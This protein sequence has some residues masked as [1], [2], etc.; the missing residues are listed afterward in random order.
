MNGA[1]MTSR[2]R[3]TMILLVALIANPLS[4]CDRSAASTV[5]LEVSIAETTL[6]GAATTGELI[7]TNTSGQRLTVDSFDTS[8]GCTTLETEQLTL[9]PGGSVRVPLEIYPTKQIGTMSVNV[10]ARSAGNTLGESS[11]SLRVVPAAPSEIEWASEIVIPL[12]AEYINGLSDA[13]CYASRN[14]D[15]KYPC[16]LDKK[17]NALRIRAPAE[18]STLDLLLER[19]VENGPST[20]HLIRIVNRSEDSPPAPTRIPEETANESSHT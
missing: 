5:R 4:A 20:N 12:P 11:F 2:I 3:P 13:R 8:C 6:A 18:A 9:A 16:E 14:S 19:P 10:R 1:R 15:V 7:V 17:A